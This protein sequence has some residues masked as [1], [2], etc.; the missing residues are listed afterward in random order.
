MTMFKQ[1]RLPLVCTYDNVADA[2]YIYLK[3]P[4]GPGGVGRMAMFEP[5]QGMFNLD[6]D[7][8]GR[9][10]GLEILDASKHLPQA[11]LQEILAQGQA[12]NER[13]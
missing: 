2:A 3:H 11:L 5:D 4:I 6:L 9:V 12:T 8:E 7:A 10:L 13:S 1:A